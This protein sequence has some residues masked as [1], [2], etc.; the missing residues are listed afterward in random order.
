MENFKHLG[1]LGFLCRRSTI[2]DVNV[3]NMKI[4]TKYKT[5]LIHKHILAWLVY[6][7][8]LFIVNYLSEST[9]L[10]ADIFALS[11][12]YAL[13]FYTSLYLLNRFIKKG[14][15]IL[16]I[17]V[18]IA[19]FFLLCLIGYFYVNEVLPIIGIRIYTEPINFLSY[20]L[21][22]VLIYIRFLIYAILYF[23][24]RNAIKKE[25]AFRL[26]ERQN[27]E[28][29]LENAKLR[30]TELKTQQEKLRFEY[31]FLRAQVN[32][33]F[34]HNTLNVLFSQA[35]PYSTSLAD[36]ILKLSNLMRYSIESLEFES[37]KVSVQKEL[38]HLQT[39]IDINNMRFANSKAIEYIVDGEV[40]GQTIPPLSMITIVE[41]AFKYGDLKD[42]RHPLKIH[43]TLAPRKIY[44]YCNNKKKKNNIQ[45]STHNIGITN[46]SKRLDIAFKDQYNMRTTDGEDF[47]TFELTINN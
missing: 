43:I 24:F 8:I 42:P 33:H 9:V 10:F 4:S 2:L 1:T 27:S 32:P 20:I 45:L 22:A 14:T 25:R 41:N 23:Q 13:V 39:L 16:G 37:G 11:I 12:M 30:E 15:R 28:R 38:E 5:T 18:I 6:D 26:I 3:G 21:S 35:M 34:L 31:A 44:F 47:Y 40:Q 7:I 29:E 46:L 19:S 17:V 36:N